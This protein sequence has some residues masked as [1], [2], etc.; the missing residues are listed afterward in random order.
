MG[1]IYYLSSQTGP[2]GPEWQAVVGH[3]GE[4]SIL[5]ALLWSAVR[6][7]IRINAANAA[8]VAIGLSVLYGI[9]DEWH[10]S[11]VPG[12]VPDP[13]DVLVD[14]AAATA[15]AAIFSLIALKG[16]RGRT[17]QPAD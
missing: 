16:E 8:L 3:L 6:G 5:S 7:T 2:G 15:A 11:L 10:Q 12:R 1:V 4:Y 14:F 13:I 9:S 17:E